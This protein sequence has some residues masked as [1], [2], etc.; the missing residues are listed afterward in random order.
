MEKQL[1]C[2]SQRV[3]ARV[4]GCWQPEPINFHIPFQCDVET[5]RVAF[6][7]GCLVR[8][9]GGGK[10]KKKNESA[11]SKFRGGAGGMGLNR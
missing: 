4:R 8:G 2:T 10:G 7:T 11:I 9:G 1:H 5:K 3:Q 6:G